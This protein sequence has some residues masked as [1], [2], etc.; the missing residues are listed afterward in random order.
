LINAQGTVDEDYTDPTFMLIINHS[1]E[2]VTIK[3]GERVCQCEVKPK[4]E[5]GFKEIYED[6]GPI[7]DRVGG[8]GHTGS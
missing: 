8:L 4:F 3:H 7:T 6:F 1:H 2:V 5:Y